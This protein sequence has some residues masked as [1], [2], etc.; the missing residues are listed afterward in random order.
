[1]EPFIKYVG[2]KRQ[3]LP[4][5]NEKKPKEFNNYFEPFVGG[6]AVFLDINPKQAIINDLNFDLI[7]CYIQIRDNLDEL[8]KILDKLQRDF[9]KLDNDEDKANYF[10]DIREKFNH[11]SGFNMIKR[12][13]YLI[14]LNK[15][16]F[17]GLYRCNSKGE[18]NV[19]FGKKK[20][21]NLYD[22]DNLKAISEKLN[23]DTIIM[24]GDFES[25]CE[26]INKGDFV[27]FDSPY[28]ET[29]DTYQKGGFSE[30]D[31]KRLNNL[32]KELDKKGVYCMLTNSDTDFIKELYK[33]FNVE[34]IEVKRMVNSDASNRKGWEVIITNY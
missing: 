11:S 13:G 32:F 12:A 9:N 2:G 31:H 10:Y 1:M 14:F 7:N 16:C 19:P 29:F 24:N 6:G 8:V 5:I 34:E 23:N 15:S 18:F 27:F 28:Y 21:L 33:D 22:L 25:A 3:L 4:I 30:E 17:N 26:T 20:K